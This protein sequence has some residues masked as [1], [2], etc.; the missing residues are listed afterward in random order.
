MNEIAPIVAPSTTLIDLLRAA[1]DKG[2]DV[3]TLE[4]LAKLY[5]AAEANAQKKAYYDALALA[6]AELKPILKDKE[7]QKANDAGKLYGY[8]TLAAIAEAIDPVLAKHGLFYRFPDGEVGS[9]QDPK[10]ITV[11]CRLSH[12][13]GYSEETT[14]T[15]PPDVGPNRN[16]VQAMG[17]TITYLQRYTLKAALGLA[18]SQDK[19]GG[20][21]QRFADR[22]EKINTPTSSEPI[23]RAYD[24][25]KPEVIQRGDEP[26]QDWT[27]WLLLMVNAAP[28]VELVDKWVEKNS[29]HLGALL[30]EIPGHHAFV[31]REK[32]KRVRKLRGSD[33]A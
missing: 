28:T 3:A 27:R 25:T 2:A 23:P 6:K 32:N 1:V 21:K 22:P 31:I 8:E 20:S 4:R 12:K 24:R 26:W 30:T 14:R 15:A 29:D 11:T 7:V 10:L 33:A 16:Q 5:E 19:D 9:S 13:E 18:V 17:S